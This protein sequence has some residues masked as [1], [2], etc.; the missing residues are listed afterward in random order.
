M[1]DASLGRVAFDPPPDAEIPE[2]FDLAEFERTVT[3]RLTREQLAALPRPHRVEREDDLRDGHVQ[4]DVV[5]IGERRLDYL[6]V[7]LD[8]EVDVVSPGDAD[9]SVNTRRDCS[10]HTSH[11]APD[12]PTVE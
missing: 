5:V 6:L 4:A 8:P 9:A 3:L 7:C 11:Q 2:W 10:R 12:V 1:V